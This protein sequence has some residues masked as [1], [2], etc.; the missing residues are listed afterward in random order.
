MI[1]DLWKI[2]GKPKSNRA[3]DKCIQ[4]SIKQQ[5]SLYGNANNYVDLGKISPNNGEH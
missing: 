3:R 1:N 4:L 5:L 2:F